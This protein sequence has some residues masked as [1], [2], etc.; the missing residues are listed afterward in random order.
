[1]K[2]SYPTDPEG[3]QL[4]AEAMR[5]LREHLSQWQF[6][7]C[8]VAALLRKLEAENGPLALSDELQNMD[9][10]AF[11]PL[12]CAQVYHAAVVASCSRH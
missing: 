8:M 9:L 2:T 11:Q 10:E 3:L 4:W 1:M 6:G 7:E 5:L 12:L